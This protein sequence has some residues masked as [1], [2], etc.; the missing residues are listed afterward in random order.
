MYWHCGIP[1]T[2][3][4]CRAAL[5]VTSRDDVVELLVGGEKED[6][7]GGLSTGEKQ[8]GLLQQEGRPF[9][10]PPNSPLDNTGRGPGRR[11][12]GWTAALC[13]FVLLT[14]S[15]EVHFAASVQWEGRLGVYRLRLAE[16]ACMYR[17]LKLFSDLFLL[18]FV[19]LYVH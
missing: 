14:A 12:R 11:R 19:Y 13:L 8:Q 15:T 1:V 4:G 9:A 6:T 5:R 3:C 7:F 17:K 2:S 16:L 10:P 18:C